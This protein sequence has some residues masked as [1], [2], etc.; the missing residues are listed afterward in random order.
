MDKI[1]TSTRI[2]S[3]AVTTALAGVLLSGC[4]TSAAP[5]ANISAARAQEAM[6]EGRHDRAVRLA[7]DAVQADPH[8]ASYRAMLG[9]AYLDAGR[10]ASAQASFDDAMTLGD[11]SPRTALSLAL[12]LTAQAKYSEAAA[13]LNDWED[14]IAT[15]DL[16][17][18]FALAGQPDRGI[19][20]MSDAIRGGE[21]TVKMR[22][23]LA[24]AFAVAGRWREAR[25]MAAQDVPAD[26]LGSRM[27]QWAAMASPTAYQTR[28]A[29]LLGTPD[30]VMDQG[31]PVHL[32][33]NN[34]PSIDQLADEATALAV[35]APA[36]PASPALAS[37]AQVAANGMAVP[38]AGAELPAVGRASV[39]QA[40]APQ[41][42]APMQAAPAQTAMVLHD[43][44]SFAAPAPA[45]APAAAPAPRYANT[46]VAPR[47][48]GQAAAAPA[49]ARSTARADAQAAAP[50][51]ATARAADGTHLVQ[52]GSF[53]TEA[54]AR[55]A[56]GIY[57]SRYPELQNHEMV[58]TEAVVRGRHYY[59][60]SAGGFD[61]A[62]SRNMC[63]RIDG[64]NGDGCITW[65]A[66]SPL[67]GAVD[68]G[69]RLAR[70]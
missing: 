60:V 3:L 65:A 8:N 49:S 18:A 57:T 41:T 28:V 64:S 58:I 48:S 13:L 66:A 32:A 14:H 19:S 29:R 46:A 7:E 67:P 26:Q 54:G 62:N 31:Q 5:Q 55:R 69:I 51:R 70:R 34:N 33:L 43:A 63:N 37:P 61:R 59:R 20:L 24:Y 15:A 21:N 9:K 42:F 4:A 1:D 23:N 53:T 25:L 10:F 40:F 68:N 45:A 17:L 12:T 56:W 38:A 16:G 27:E 30:G 35:A 22:Q 2:A 47:V 52:L 6:A 39:A 36:A 44:G 50:A 11:L